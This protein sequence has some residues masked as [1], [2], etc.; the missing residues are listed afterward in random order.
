MCILSQSLNLVLIDDN[1]DHL[2]LMSSTVH[3]AFESEALSVTTSNYEDPAE[4]LTELSDNCNQ[5][6]LIDYQLNQGTGIDWLVDFLKS[7]VGPVILVTSSGDE[8]IAAESFRAGAYDYIVKSEAIRNPSMLKRSVQEALRKFKLERT[9][10]ELSK[11]LKVA[12]KEL[13]QK[14]RKLTELT[15]TAHRFVEDVAHEFRT[16]LTVIKEFASILS[17]GLGGEVTAKQAEYLNY[18][19]GSTS[20]LAGLIDDFLNSSR[21]RSNSICVERREVS[22]HELIDG[23]RPMLQS[24]AATKSIELVFMIPD[25]I[26]NIFVDCDKAQRS[27]INLTINA[28]KFSESESVVRVEAQQVS[29]DLLSISVQ[30]F[31]PGLPEDSLKKLFARFNT[32]TEEVRETTNGFGL[33]L[34]IVK[35]LVSINLGEVTIKSQL[36]EGS[37]FTFTV[38]VSS[39]QSIVRGL[40]NQC[41]IKANRPQIGVLSARRL[42]QDQSNQELMD[43]INDL[44]Y[45]LDLVIESS[46]ENGIFIIGITNDLNAFRNRILL[47]D[48]DR[49]GAKGVRHSALV[50]ESLGVWSPDTAEPNILALLNAS[51]HREFSRA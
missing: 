3:A 22:L 1:A 15:D 49:Q 33:G 29:D 30:D 2:N 27:L 42:N 10:L 24:R 6:I 23:V 31:G 37:T 11:R 8:R 4:A 19:S 20:D 32:G 26:P 46:S 47:A 39:Q 17:D 36:G 44:V 25:D 28:I 16:P 35:E 34:S 50:L 21:L 51:P 18:I 41:R 12:N 40:I 5:V 45:P 48:S 9:N 43:L 13:Q 38:P 14:N 7:D